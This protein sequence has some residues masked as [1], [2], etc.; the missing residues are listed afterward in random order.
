ME[1]LQ[2]FLTMGGYGGYVWPAYGIGA[3]AMI[4]LLAL[5]VRE[6]RGREAELDLLQ[7]A[8]QDRAGRRRNG[9]KEAQS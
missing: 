4:A 9:N 6:T 7:Q 8:R 5:S 3:I 2:A 1:S